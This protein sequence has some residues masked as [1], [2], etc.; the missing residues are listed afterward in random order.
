MQHEIIDSHIHPALDDSQWICSFAGMPSPKKQVQTLRKNG[1]SRA[2][3][4]VIAKGEFKH[5]SE[6]EKLN[7]DAFR[8]RDQFPD[9][10]IPG[11]HIHPHFPQESCRELERCHAEGL[12][13]IG[14]LVGYYMNYGDHYMQDGAKTIYQKADDLG[15]VVNFHCGDLNV[16]RKMCE[17]FPNLRF[18]LAHPG[19]TADCRLRVQLVKNYPNLYLDLSGTGVMRLG[20]IRHAVDKA[21]SDKILTEATTRPATRQCTSPA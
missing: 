5:F 14:E 18:V 9:F 13:W 17:E 8:F 15:M 10:Y 12:R 3:G 16:I 20:M 1:I 19:N 7:R 11:I 2:C 21:G 4:S 6:V